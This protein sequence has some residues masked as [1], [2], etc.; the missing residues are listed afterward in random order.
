MLQFLKY[1]LATVIGLVIFSLLAFFIFLGFIT[2]ASSGDKVTV[3]ENSVL[4]LKF[5]KPIVERGRENDSFAELANSLSGNPNSVGL[6]QIRQTIADAKN[7]NNIKGIYLEPDMYGATAG[8]PTLEEIRT[9]LA[10]FKKSGKFIIAYGEYYTEKSI[11]LA[12]IADKIYLN[13]EGVV[14]WNGLSTSITFLKGTL[15]K[16][17]VKPEVFKVGDYKSA[18]EPFLRQDMS[19][20][21]REQTRSFLTSINSH[22]LKTISDARGISTTELQALA[23]SL[24]IR[25]PK[26]AKQYK[27]VTD[28]GYADEVETAIKKALKQD[29][30]KKIEFISFT[31]YNKADNKE[32]S[33]SGSSDNRIAVI[34]A[35]GEINSGD[36][37]D[38]S[39]GSDRIAEALRK[40]R[41]DEKIKAVVLR[42][43]SPGG[44]SLA[45][46]VMWREI[47]LTKEKKPVV[48]SMSDYAASGGYYMA[49]GCDKIIAHPTTLTGS[50][51]VFGLWFNVKDLLNDKLGVTVDGVKTNS[52]ADIGLPTRNMS[53]FERQWFQKRTESVYEDFTSKAAKGRKMNVEDLRKI[54]SGRVWTGEQA[55]QNG[56]VDALGGMEDA[57][58]EAAK[59]AKLKE[60]DYRLRYLPEQKPLIEELF[61]S[62]SE[63]M[64]TKIIQKHTGALA[65]YIKDIQKLKSWQ[66]TQT[67]LPFEIEIR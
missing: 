40:A 44:S 2:A 27:L 4:K 5:D 31:K 57:V 50:I 17:G 38:E 35:S 10:D 24:T 42:I 16:L 1:V 32:K 67:R 9:S 11:Y 51:G 63:T 30:K 7:D 18:V 8:Y 58:A 65:P 59:L 6:I 25:E 49:M 22:L 34:V 20:P 26:D 36:G 48:A 29:D 47:Q 52:Y 56:L 55:K 39:I 54:A 33:E 13:P 53:D 12:S 28:V 45:S 66:G 37:G 46:D 3:K 14:E 19:E 64:E 21:S 15:D 41:E 60:G 43:N 23:D 62:S 61:G